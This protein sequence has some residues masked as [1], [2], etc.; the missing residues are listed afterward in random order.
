MNGAPAATLATPGSTKGLFQPI[1]VGRYHLKHRVAMAPLT[2]IRATV[3]NDLT[4]A[5]ENVPTALMATYYGQRATKGGLIIAEATV[6]CPE[7]R[8]RTTVPGVYTDAQVEGWRAVTGAVHAKGGVVFLQLWHVG[9]LSHSSYD[10]LGRPPPS[11]STVR[12]S[13]KVTTRTQ[14]P[15][16]REVPR[17]LKSEEIPLLIQQFVRAAERAIEAGFDGVEIH[18][19]NGYIVDQF[20]NDSVNC[21]RSDAYGG[22]AAG[23]VRLAIQIVAAVAEAIGADR[24]AIRLSP[25]LDIAF[26]HLV[27]P[28]VKGEDVSLRPFRQAYTGTLIVA[29]GLTAE[30]AEALVK[31]GEADLAAFGRYYPPWLE[32]QANNKNSSAKTDELMDGKI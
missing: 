1:Q 3:R 28:R 25:P 4:P 27:Q 22:D 19:A 14:G 9:R 20:I 21:E 12:A 13:G 30:S 29:D 11:S 26:V 16:D 10:P 23:R 6:V 18:G 32:Q 2:R 8:P 15:I 5:E 17:M 24:T 31:N 7:G